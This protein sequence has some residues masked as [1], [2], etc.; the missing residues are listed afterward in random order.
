M[1]QEK[2]E[3]SRMLQHNSSSLF[4][5]KVPQKIYL[6]THENILEER[7]K[8]INFIKRTQGANMSS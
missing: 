6:K 3:T 1:I 4:K 5:L 2:N 8:S 7:D